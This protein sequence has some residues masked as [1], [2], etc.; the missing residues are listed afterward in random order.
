[1]PHARGTSL[2]TLNN[3]CAYG[4]IHPLSCGSYTQTRRES[5]SETSTDSAPVWL[6][7][8]PPA[9]TILTPLRCLLSRARAHSSVP[10]RV[11]ASQPLQRNAAPQTPS[12][13]ARSCWRECQAS[14]DLDRRRVDRCRAGLCAQDRAMVRRALAHVRSI[15]ATDTALAGWLVGWGLASS[16]QVVIDLPHL[17]ESYHASA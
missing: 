1:V 15:D 16:Q 11:S 13:T 6:G 10:A 8:S 4:A 2:D 17:R 7:N 3:I 5:E 12:R 9:T 14:Q